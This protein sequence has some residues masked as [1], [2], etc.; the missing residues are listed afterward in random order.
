MAEREQIAR[1]TKGQVQ[2]KPAW[3]TP[4]S[5]AR[6]HR[7]CDPSS[8]Q[9][10]WFLLKGTDTLLSS[11]AACSWAQQE[12]VPAWKGCTGGSPL[13]VLCCFPSTGGT[14]SCGTGM[15]RLRGSWGA[16]CPHHRIFPS[17]V[18]Q[19]K[20]MGFELL[21]SLVFHKA[22]QL[23]QCPI[24]AIMGCSGVFW[25]EVPHAPKTPET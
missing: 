10:S 23:V 18:L 2:T 7:C 16:A 19:S 5:P 9:P 20:C 15:L 13:P 22:P 8:P 14:R 4:T 17:S 1:H 12:K 3:Q 24:R 6:S 25:K 21:K 11:G